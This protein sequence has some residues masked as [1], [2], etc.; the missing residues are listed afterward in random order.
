MNVRMRDRG[1]VTV[2]CSL[3]VMFHFRTENVSIGQSCDIVSSFDWV[4]GIFYTTFLFEVLLFN[5]PVWKLTEVVFV[6]IF[7]TFRY[8][9]RKLKGPFQRAYGIQAGA[10]LV[11]VCLRSQSIIA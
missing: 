3:S 2:I 8:Q 1:G 11:K 6:F 7:F 9:V 4:R 5:V 10:A